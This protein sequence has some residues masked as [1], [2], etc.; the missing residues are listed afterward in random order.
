MCQIVENVT[1]SLSQ[2]VVE[3]RTEVNKLSDCLRDSLNIQ[4][5]LLKQWDQLTTGNSPPPAVPQSPVF[6]MATSIP[7]VPARDKTEPTNSTNPFLPSSPFQPTNPFLPS[8]S[9]EL[10]T[11]HLGV[12]K[13]LARL[14]F[15]FFWPK[16]AADVKRYVTS[17]AG[18]MVPI[19]P[20]KPWEYVGVDFVGPLPRTPTGNAY[21]IVFVDY[22]TK[23]VEASA[24][25]EATSQVE[26]GKFVTD[27]FAR[28]GTPTYLISDRGSPFVSELFEH[29]VSALGSVHRL[30]T[31]Y[32]PQ[33]N[34]TERVN[35]TLKTAI[36]AYVGDK[37]TSW[38]RFLP[39]ICFALRTAPHDSTGMTPAMMLYGRE[40]DT[41]LD[42]IT[43]PSTAGVDKPGVPYPETLRASLQEA[44]DHAKAALDYR[45]YPKNKVKDL[46]LVCF[47]YNGR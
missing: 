29:V 16:M 19:V 35:R 15:R 40:L 42:L 2:Q 18:L 47:R 33:T 38:D 36:R 20:Q 46:I 22:L 37:H 21:L 45:Q 28:H 26:A 13:T 6:P 39:Q 12:S 3:L 4:Q 41:P 5:S 9:L 24:V 8:H 25:K 7:H 31:A 34:A 14:R 23:W 43:Q 1:P 30:T 32:Q 44:H 17:S 11:G 27:I 10:S